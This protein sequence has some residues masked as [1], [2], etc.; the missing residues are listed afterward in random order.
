MKKFLLT[1]F[2]LFAF[3]QVYS[4]DIVSITQFGYQPGSRENAVP[5]VAKALAACMSKGNAILVFP[6]GRYDFWPQY[7]AEK[8][9]YESNTDVIPFRTCPILIEDISNLT[10][11]GNGSDFIFHG[12]VQPFT[13]NASSNIH[14]KNINVDWDIPLTAQAEI[15]A[16]T[17]DHIDL[18]INAYESPYIIE[19]NKLVF[20]GEG[21]K[22]RFW[23]AMEFDRNAKLI[24]TQT[25]D[26]CLGK[27]WGSYK[28][29]ELSK[30]LVRFTYPF[31][32]KP[33][34][35]NYLVLR[36]SA[37]DHAGTFI[38][39][40]KNIT[41]ENFNLFETAGLGILSQYSENL[42]FNNVHCVP[43]KAKNRYFSGHDDGLHFSNCKGTILVD[44]CRFAGLM[45]DPINVHGTS[46]LITEK[47][48][49]RVL[50][51][52]FVHPQSIG[53]TWAETGDEIGFIEN[54]SMST[55]GKGKAASF[56]KIS[57]EEFELRF[58]DNVPDSITKGD[59]L[60]NLTWTPAITIRNSYF[61]SNRARGILIST[62]GDV[63]IENNIFESSG[64]A[65]L[66]PGD[67]NGWYESGA[68]KNVTIRHNLFKEAC[69][70]SIYQ[71]CEGIISIDPEIPKPQADK[72][73]HRNILIENNTFHPFDYPVLYAKSTDGLIFSNNII[74][75]STKYAP[76]HPRKYMIS[77]EGCKNVQ[78][79]NKS[80][81]GEVLGK[82][83]LLTRTP[84]AEVQY[85]KSLK[86]VESK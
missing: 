81:A 77:L 44:S 46:V 11:E 71:F 28:A 72:P 8:A 35:G 36:H 41:L 7:S 31:T 6:K 18:K 14:I 4:Q 33:A 19:Q 20:I 57:A 52:R 47:L 1:G 39:N 82:N 40:S 37:R 21:W 78:V 49:N 69:L 13:I 62:P 64:S 55:I 59:A 30:G 25:D 85:D 45:D 34:L 38:Q 86:I 60:E 15:V 17:N 84:I 58:S 10:I 42:V 24:V 12:R 32:R 74:Q 66:I 27:N 9:F 53:F 73:F 56:Q 80:L 61:G 68:V 79:H 83:I 5:F 2:T 50:R 29:S 26:N 23:D 70:S 3:I 22:S 76:F 16:V 54:E 65:I 75:R 67:A 48:N 51:C 43:N 63:L